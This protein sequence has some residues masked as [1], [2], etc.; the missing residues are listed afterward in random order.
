MDISN[1]IPFYRELL[2]R[3]VSATSSS[4]SRCVLKSFF[5]RLAKSLEL[6]SLR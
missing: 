3:P 4:V 6:T 5:V 1:L 2:V